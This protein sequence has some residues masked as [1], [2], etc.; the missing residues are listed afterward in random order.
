MQQRIRIELEE[1]DK[2]ENV[3]ADNDNCLFSVGYALLC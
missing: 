2:E 3:I 1:I